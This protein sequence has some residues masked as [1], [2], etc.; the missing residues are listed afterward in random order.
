[1]KKFLQATP[2]FLAF[3]TALFLQSCDKEEI[4]PAPTVEVNPTSA[5]NVPGGKVTAELI[6]TAPNGAQ[7]LIVYVAGTQ[8]EERDLTT[9]DINEPLPFEYTIPTTAKV[10]AQ[11]IVAF[12]VIDNKNYP[13]AIANFVITVGDPVITLQGN[14]TTQTLDASKPYILKGQVF[15]PNGVTLTIPEGTIIKGDKS[16]KATLIVQPGGKLIA[17]G[18]AAKPVVF[19]SA[20]NVGERDRGDWGGLVILGNA[21]V[22]QTAKP[23]IEGITPTQNYGS[24]SADGATPATNASENSGSLKYVRIEYAGIELTPNNETNS[25]T[26]GAVGN[27]TTVEYV[28]VSFGGDDGFEWFGGTVNGKYLVSHSTWDD[29][30]DTDFGWGGNVQFG[31]V[32]RNPFFAD[33]S[34][35]NAFESDNQGNGNAIAG[36]CDGTTNT[37]CTR[38]VFSNITVLGPRETNS[39]S[40]SANYQNAIHIRRRSAISIFNSF[41]SGFRV[42]LRLDDQSTLD[43]LT[44]GTSKH[45]YNVLSVPGTVLKGTSTS[46]ADAAYAT[47]LSSGDAAAVETYWT[48]NNN[49]T[50][51]NVTATTAFSA[52]GLTPSLFWG[53]QTASNYPSNPSFVLAAGSGANDLNTGANFADAKVSGS[54]FTATTFR[55]AFGST[56]WTDG[57]A[58]FQPLNKAY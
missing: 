8:Q 2:L 36:I 47:G 40:I 13:S 50:F 43:N 10:G 42:G 4:E 39:R 1:M 25:L 26:M 33:Q 49:T 18:T 28:Q 46:A 55:G 16:T 29:D 32:V 3:A 17:N 31:L 34:G 56:D 7:T 35:S 22:N 6:V 11:I 44:A 12:Q 20:Q 58:E 19:T 52:I 5:T 45:A 15:I 38:G 23:T 30:F 37:G 53:T 41:F 9:A 27:G 24:V 48:G 14:L 57:W 51:N 21:F 54:F